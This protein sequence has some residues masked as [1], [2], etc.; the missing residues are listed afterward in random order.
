MTGAPEQVNMNLDLPVG[1]DKEWESM[2]EAINNRNIEYNLFDNDSD[3]ESTADN[4]FVSTMVD[5]V[6]EKDDDITELTGN[7]SPEPTEN[8]CNEERNT[9]MTNMSNMHPPSRNSFFTVEKGIIMDFDLSA[10]DVDKTAASE[11]FK[12]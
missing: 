10:L 8:P 11:L 12:V 4:N 2:H 3:T 7:P 1:E 5:I 9:N 6:S